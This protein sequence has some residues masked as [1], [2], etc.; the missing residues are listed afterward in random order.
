MLLLLG[1]CRVGRN[2]EPFGGTLCQATLHQTTSK[3]RAV[4]HVCCLGKPLCLTVNLVPPPPPHH[5]CSV[6][7]HRCCRQ[8]LPRDEKAYKNNAPS[9]ALLSSH[10]IDAFDFEAPFFRNRATRPLVTYRCGDG[11]FGGIIY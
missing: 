7:S 10:N 2:V 6:V 5:H 9:C 11:T 1:V 3:N 8:P 4:E